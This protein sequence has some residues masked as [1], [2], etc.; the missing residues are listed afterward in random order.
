MSWLGNTEVRGWVPWA[1]LWSLW[2]TDRA[3]KLVLKSIGVATRGEIGEMG[4]WGEIAE[5]DDVV[6][7]VADGG[8]D[9]DSPGCVDK[10][11]GD[12]EMIQ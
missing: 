5:L 3:L 1:D 9:G 6:E 2:L 7:Q 12:M 10:G 11:V 8:A 4:K